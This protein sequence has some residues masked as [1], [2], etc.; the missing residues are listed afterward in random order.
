MLGRS[1][2]TRNLLLK[3]ERRPER[4]IKKK[5]K[6]RG[7]GWQWLGPES[8]I[9]VVKGQRLQKG[10]VERRVQPGQGLALVRGRKG[11]L[12]AAGKGVVTC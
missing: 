11:R 5:E 3:L 6:K 9:Q 12:L 4:P 1:G 10:H 8:G 2:E 7:K